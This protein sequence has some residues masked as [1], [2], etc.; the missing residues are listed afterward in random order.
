L[1]LF[2]EAL[3]PGVAFC[4]SNPLFRKGGGPVE[5]DLGDLEPGMLPEALSDSEYFH[6][7]MTAPGF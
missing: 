2:A 7:H 1:T 5:S 6:Q 3:E 4:I